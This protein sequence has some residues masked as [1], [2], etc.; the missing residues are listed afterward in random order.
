METSILI[1]P[2]QPALV[3]RICNPDGISTN[4][5]QWPT[6]GPVTCP[7]WRENHR[8]GNGLHGWL[9]GEGNSSMIPAPELFSNPD[10]L[11]LVVEVPTY[12]QLNGKVKFEHG[13]VVASGSSAETTKYLHDNFR[14]G[15]IIGTTIIDTM[16]SLKNFIGGNYTLISVGDD[17][18]VTAGDKSKIEVG[19]YSYIKAGNDSICT[20]KAISTVIVG[21]SSTATTGFRGVS[22]ADDNGTAIAGDYGKATAGDSGTAIVGKRGVATVSSFGRAKAGEEGK[23]IIIDCILYVGEIGITLDNYGN[24]LE[25]DVFYRLDHS[26][27][28]TK[29]PKFY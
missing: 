21:R 9:N 2:K 12:I 10:A 17:C 15:A 16:A 4:S 27:K 22:T 24:V 28:F 3:L 11:W 18:T 26:G 25:A 23:I 5:F 29:M 8:C 20:G 1:T 6:K 14:T 7:D 19:S 13:T